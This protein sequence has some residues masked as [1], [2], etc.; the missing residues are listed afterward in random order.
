MEDWRA[1]IALCGDADLTV[2]LVTSIE[3]LFVS[4]LH[5]LK[6][7]AS[8]Q[9]IAAELATRLKAHTPNAEDGKPWDVSVEYN[10]KGTQIKTIHG[11][12]KVRPDI[13]LHRLGTDLNFLAIELKK[14]SSA[15]ASPDDALKLEAYRRPNELNYRHA[16]FLR[17][18]VKEEAGR[19]TAVAW[20]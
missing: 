13:I 8:E 7:D 20:F 6:V 4:N 1:F 12:Q 17:L 2:A 16:L 14:G 10:R 18:G 3:E 5:S 19:V 9:H 11:T 15:E